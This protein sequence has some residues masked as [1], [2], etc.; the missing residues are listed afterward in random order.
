MGGEHASNQVLAGRIDHV[1]QDDEEGNQTE[2]LVSQHESE[3]ATERHCFLTGRWRA[4][5]AVQPQV[6]GD[7][8][9][10]KGGG[11]VEDCLR[12]D[13][14]LE[15]ASRHERSKRRARRHAD[16]DDGKQAAARLFAV[17]VVGERPELRD[18]R[19]VED[20]DPD[21]EGHAHIRQTGGDRRGE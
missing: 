1:Q 12:R 16:R 3:S 18:E 11:D 4:I 19:H 21:E 15:Q 5:P 14:R 13:S 7:A 20:A 17:D 8:R 6:E 9:N 10:E 2:V